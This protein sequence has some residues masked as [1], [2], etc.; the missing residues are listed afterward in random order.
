MGMKELKYLAAYTIPVAA[1]IAIYFKGAWS[2]AG[3]AYPFIVIPIL[4]LL[5]GTNNDNYSETTI[6]KRSANPVFDW[7]LYGN[8]LWVF[9]LL[10]YGFRELAS[11][12]LYVFETIGL[13]L[14]LGILLATNAI[15]VAHELGHRNNKKDQFLSKLLLLPCLYVHFFVEHNYG[16]HQKVAT[17]ED[18][19]SARFNQS[20]YAFYWQ[21]VFGQYQSAWKLQK[22]LLQNSGS[23]FLSI[24]NIVFWGAIAQIVYILVV[25]YVFGTFVGILA[26]VIGVVSFLMLE[27]I[28][29]IEHYGLLREKTASGRY[30]KTQDKHSWNSDHVIG[31][32]VLYE[33]TRHSDHHFKTSKKYQ[34]LNYYDTSPQL[35]YGY[36]TSILLALIPPLWF[37]IVNPH[38]P[39]SMKNN[40]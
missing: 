21:S 7:M 39:E 16:H 12:Q 38:V 30:E 6:E 33:L 17:P 23:P 28:N 29:Y 2:F 10:F 37:R 9:G 26:A 40:F 11:S 1:G 31:R 5:L 19:A 36:P 18:P 34:E 14:S 4:E 24:K 3:V 13:V 25:F 27:S 22:K 15:N 20:V 32:V 35:P 8:I